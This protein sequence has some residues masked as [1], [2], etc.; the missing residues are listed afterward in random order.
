MVEFDANFLEVQIKIANKLVCSLLCLRQKCIFV[1]CS[2]QN[3]LNFFHLKFPSRFSE[4]WNLTKKNSVDGK[5]GWRWLFCS[6]RGPSALGGSAMILVGEPF[7]SKIFA[8]EWLAIS[9]KTLLKNILANFLVI[10]LDKRKLIPPD[11]ALELRDFL[12]SLLHSESEQRFC[13]W[14]DYQENI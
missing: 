2:F 7:K 9:M 10:L 4:T 1:F 11:V 6:F 13:F 3:I 8:E 14:L 5:P 12:R